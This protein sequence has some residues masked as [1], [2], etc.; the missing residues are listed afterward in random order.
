MGGNNMG[1]MNMNMWTCATYDDDVT[2]CERKEKKCVF[3]ATDTNGDGL[4]NP[5][6]CTSYDGRKGC[7]KNRKRCVWD[8]DSRECSARVE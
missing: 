7:K 5:R 8:K 1:G 6:P 2:E 3:Y 4:C